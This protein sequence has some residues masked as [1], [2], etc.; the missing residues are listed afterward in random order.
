MNGWLVFE[1]TAKYIH[2]IHWIH[3]L[4]IVRLKPLFCCFEQSVSEQTVAC[5][6]VWQCVSL[7]RIYWPLA[8][9]VC[10]CS[11]SAWNQ[12][13][14]KKDWSDDQGRVTLK[15]QQ[16]KFMKIYL[17]LDAKSHNLKRYCSRGE[18]YWLLVG[19]TSD[20]LAIKS[21]PFWSS[22]EVQVSTDNKHSK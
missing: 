21:S 16:H 4:S 19:C 5:R 3:Q 10:D 1:F 6:E 11:L 15:K 22:E 8:V 7:D 17:Y 12:R 14:W 2:W 9:N 20:C 18:E 13:G